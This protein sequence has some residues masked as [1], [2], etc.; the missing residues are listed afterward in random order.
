MRA[1]RTEQRTDQWKNRHQIRAG[2]E[3]AISQGVLRCD[4]CGSHYRSLTKTGLQHQLTGA[5]I[6]LARIDAHP[7]GQRRAPTRTSPF[8]ALRPVG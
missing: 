3:G 5:A 1:A 2:V 8:A 7:T 4:L 6:N